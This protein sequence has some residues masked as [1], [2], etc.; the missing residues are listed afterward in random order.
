[1]SETKPND[2]VGR[3]FL[4]F[5]ESELGWQGQILSMPSSEV[6]LVQLYSWLDGEP[7]QQRFVK[8]ADMLEWQFYATDDEMRDA[9]ERVMEKE[10]FA[11][12]FAKQESEVKV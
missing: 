9:A 11:E 8:F 1:M 7:S 5:K 12:R 2:L 4:Q 10:W 3:W 6:Y